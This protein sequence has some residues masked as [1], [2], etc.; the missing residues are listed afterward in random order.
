MAQHVADPG[1]LLPRDV[2]MPRFHGGWEMPACL[3]DDF[4][5][6]RDDPG[7]L[8]IGFE[9]VERNVGG[10][11]LDTLDRLRDIHQAQRE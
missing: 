8:L 9:G 3:G 10:H 11:Q 5:A 4:E 2:R 1:D 6:A 7:L